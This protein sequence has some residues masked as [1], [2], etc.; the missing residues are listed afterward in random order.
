MVQKYSAIDYEPFDG[1]SYYRLKQVDND[2]KYSHSNIVAVNRNSNDAILIYPNPATGPFNIVIS[3]QNGRETLI[4]IRDLLGK[5]FYS[6]LLIL[7]GDKEVIA[8]DPTGTLAAGVY[9]V[10]AT[11]D[12]NIFE[13]KV[14]IK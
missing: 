4:V 14:I 12:N 3:G 13:K 10:V 11:S 8:M 6:K 2:G 7:S 9:F 5:E 1:I